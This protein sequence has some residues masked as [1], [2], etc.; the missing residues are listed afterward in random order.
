MSRGHG[1]HVVNLAIGASAVVIWCAIPASEASFYRKGLGIERDS[2]TVAIAVVSIAFLFGGVL[3][4]RWLFLP[5]VIFPGTILRRR[6]LY[7]R[8]RRSLHFGLIASCAP[9]QRNQDKNQ[10]PCKSRY[11]GGVGY[12]PI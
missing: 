12:L 4:Q 11:L 2:D 10:Q 9:G 7:G 3:A 1:V 5:I 8:R 6:R